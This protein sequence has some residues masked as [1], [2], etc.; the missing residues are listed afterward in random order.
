[1][2][3]FFSVFSRLFIIVESSFTLA[4][5]GMA[6]GEVKALH[7]RLCSELHLMAFILPIA[8]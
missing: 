4:G 3:Y 7:Y 6:I 2:V 1:M 5:N 8:C